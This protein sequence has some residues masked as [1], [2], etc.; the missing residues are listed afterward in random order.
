MGNKEGN[1]TV[2]FSSVHFAIAN[3]GKNRYTFQTLMR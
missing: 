2:P 1:D 3:V